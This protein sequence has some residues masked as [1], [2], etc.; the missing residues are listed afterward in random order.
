MFKGLRS[1]AEKEELFKRVSRLMRM[2]VP[3]NYA[4]RVVGTTPET[5][6]KIKNEIIG[7]NKND[8]PPSHTVG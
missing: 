5:Y 2:E 7:S 8:V 6:R 3:V 4:C 1:K